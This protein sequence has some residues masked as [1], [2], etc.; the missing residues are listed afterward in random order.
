MHKQQCLSLH[1]T[2]LLLSRCTF[3]SSRHAAV[4]T[5]AFAVVSLATSGVGAQLW[6]GF[7]DLDDT[8]KAMV[9]ML[10]LAGSYLAAAAVQTLAG[11][12]SDAAAPAS[13]K[14]SFLPSKRALQSLIV[15]LL[16]PVS[17][18]S[19][20][21][22]SAPLAAAEVKYPKNLVSS[23]CDEQQMRP[24]IAISERWRW[25]ILGL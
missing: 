19:L 13:S 6:E 23:V 20:S 2:E 9:A 21:G 12:S 10:L 5:A 3:V 22:K 14:R 25:P 7:V 18:I 8:S 16:R 4:A 11:S 15:L 24:L 17:S 1:T